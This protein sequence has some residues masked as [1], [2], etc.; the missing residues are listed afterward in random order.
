MCSLGCKNECS[1]LWVMMFINNSADFI[2]FQAF[3]DMCISLKFTHSIIAFGV[4]WLLT[5]KKNSLD[6]SQES[7]SFIVSLGQFV[8]IQRIGRLLGK[9]PH[10]QTLHSRHHGRKEGQMSQSLNRSLNI[11][12]CFSSITRVCALILKKVPPGVQ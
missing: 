6:F 9:N 2:I 11:L 7:Y 8:L 4:C 3:W 10:A 12:K 1:V 5:R